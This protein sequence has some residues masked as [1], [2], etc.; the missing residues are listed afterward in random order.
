MVEVQRMQADMLGYMPVMQ[1]MQHD[2][3]LPDTQHADGYDVF[4]SPDAELHYAT[5]ELRQS[6]YEVVQ[7]IRD[8]FPSD[9]LQ[10]CPWPGMA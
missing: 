2:L 6:V 8:R 3:D 5:D 9:I 7:E 1:S 4:D 10:T